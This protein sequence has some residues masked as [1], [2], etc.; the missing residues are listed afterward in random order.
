[1][2][3]NAPSAERPAPVGSYNEWDPLEEVIVGVVDGAAVPPWHPAIEATVPPEAWDFYR[4]NGGGGFP[5]EQVEAAREELDG[6]ASILEGEGV[7]VRRPDPV[8]QSRPFGTADWTSTGG[9]SHTF[10]RDIALVAGD[11]IVEATMGWR[12]YYFATHPFRTIFKDYF[13]RGARWVAAPKPQLT[14]ASF[15]PGYAAAKRR[16]CPR[17]T[18]SRTPPPSSPSSSRSWTRAT[19]CGSAATSSSSA[20]TSPT[21]SASSGCGGCSAA[22]SGCTR[23]PSPTTTRCT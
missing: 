5:R 14:D 12:S 1:M 2:T 11:Q 3:E 22:S 9:S 4:R 21:G 17:T 13:R 18:R 16:P 19:S 10:P 20:A 8:D 7:T 15:N 23:S 6:F